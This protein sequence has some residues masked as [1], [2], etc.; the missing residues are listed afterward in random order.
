MCSA[1]AAARQ[2]GGDDRLA[3][4]LQRAR[5]VDALAARQ[6]QRRVGAVAPAQLEVRH[7]HRAVERRVERDRD[8]HGT[9]SSTPART[10]SQTLGSPADSA[11]T[12]SRRPEHAL[13]LAQR[14]AA[15]DLALGDRRVDLGRGR[16]GLGDRL[17]RGAA[18]RRAA[19]PRGRA[20]TSRAGRRPGTLPK[21]APSGIRVAVA[22]WR[23]AVVEQLPA[24]A[25]ARGRARRADQGRVQLGRLRPAAG[26]GDEGVA[27][28]VGH[29]GLD[30][31]DV[32]VDV[33]QVVLGD[34]V[35]ACRRRPAP[36]STRAGA[37]RSPGRPGSSWR[38]APGSRGRGRST[39][40]RP[41]RGRA[42]SRSAWPSGRARG[43][44]GSCARRTPPG[45]P[46]T[47]SARVIAA[48]LP[49]ATSSAVSRSRTLSCS[50]ATSRPDEPPTAASAGHR[51]DVVEAG[52]T[53]ARRAPS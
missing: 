32:R 26:V 4:R 53:R 45:E 34:V 17:A 48:S 5:H 2:A 13:A 1:D 20:R 8:D 16:D 24:V 31:V 9:S 23:A 37:R 47:P 43:P 40:A 21:T 51:V 27:G 42:G 39:G 46:A 35:A 50:P 49:L 19:R 52:A 15:D 11:A 22:Y 12:R 36:G 3:E 18:A 33:E 38:P 6:A 41:R 14:D 44:G 10:R 7:A 30:P 29:P 28:A 25:G